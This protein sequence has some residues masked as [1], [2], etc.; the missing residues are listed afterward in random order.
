MPENYLCAQRDSLCHKVYF[1]WPIIT[2][3]T[4]RVNAVLFTWKRGNIPCV[5]FMVPITNFFFTLFVFFL[6][7]QSYACIDFLISRKKLR[8]FVRERRYK[9]ILIQK[10]G[11][12][13][14][15]TVLQWCPFEQGFVMKYFLKKIKQRLN[16]YCLLFAANLLVKPQGSSWSVH[17]D[18]SCYDTAN[19][20]TNMFNW[21]F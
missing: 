14:N 6:L 20:W 4:K 5:S 1:E 21:G 11:I 7:L 2:E 16:K 15:N 3:Q 19:T 18:N 17:Y 10:F 8:L 9:T 12:Y 13:L